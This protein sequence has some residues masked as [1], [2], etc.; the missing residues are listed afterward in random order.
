MFSFIPSF[1]IPDYD[2]GSFLKADERACFGRPCRKN[3]LQ[4]NSENP[5]YDVEEGKYIVFKGGAKD[6][7]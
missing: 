3:F 5:N 4:L 2:G 7:V 6:F 1:V